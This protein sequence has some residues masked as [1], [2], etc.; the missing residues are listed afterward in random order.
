VQCTGS[1]PDLAHTAARASYQRASFVS[2][3]PFTWKT[4]GSSIVLL[5]SGQGRI[6]VEVQQ[7]IAGLVAPAR[8]AVQALHSRQ[9]KLEVLEAAKILL[10]NLGLALASLTSSMEHKAQSANKVWREIV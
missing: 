1:V 8:V 3:T 6:L 9:Q 4:G 5:W 10:L 7:A 2:A